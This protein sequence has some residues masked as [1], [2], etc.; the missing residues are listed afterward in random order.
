MGL[1]PQLTLE[2]AILRQGGF[3]GIPAGASVSEL[4][5]V[6]ISGNNPPGEQ[7]SLELKLKPSDPPQPP[8]EAAD[9][10]RRELEKLIRK[11]E[12]EGQGYTSLNL[13]MWANRYGTYD[14]L[15]RIKEWSAAGGLGIE[16][17]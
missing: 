2:A 3:E 5:Y 1:S 13:S 9:H 6:R 7:R 10:A 12:D 11:F 14:D 17:W 16:E 8:D 4:V 15:A